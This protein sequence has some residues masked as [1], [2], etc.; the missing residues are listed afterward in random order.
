MPDIRHLPLTPKR[1]PTRFARHPVALV[2]GLL[3]Q[4]V[5]AT[6][7]AQGDLASE[8]PLVLRP[9]PMLQMPKN[10]GIAPPCRACTGITL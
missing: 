6:A 8:P 4:G 9:S 10:G 2:V 3:L 5:V 1:F 7:Q